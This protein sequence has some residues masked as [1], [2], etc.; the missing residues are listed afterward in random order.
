M[1][2][3]GEEILGLYRAAKKCLRRLSS[4]STMNYRNILSKVTVA[5][6]QVLLLFTDIFI[7]YLGIVPWNVSSGV[8]GLRSRPVGVIFPRTLNVSKKN[9][10]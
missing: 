2:C 8:S 10:S 7:D 1:S 5:S 6:L 9:F 3:C 4:F